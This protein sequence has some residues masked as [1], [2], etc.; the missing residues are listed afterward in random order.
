MDEIS[1][2][3][4][5]NLKGFINNKNLGS[6]DGNWME[7]IQLANIHSVTGILGY[8]VM[9]YPDESNAQVAPLMRKQCL[10]SIGIFSQ[11]AEKMKLLLQQMNEQG[12]DHLLF[13]GYVLKDY[14][15]VPELRSYGDIDF[16]IRLDDR[17]KS[18]ALMMHNC[19]ERKTDW[20]PVFSYLKEL[21][22]YEI[23]TDVMEVDVSDKADY[24][25]YFSHTW[26]RAKWVEG[27][28]WMLSPEDHL[29]YLLTH[30]AKH[31][32][33]SGAGI[34]MYMDIAVFLQHFSNDLDWDYLQVELEKLCFIDFVNM[35]LSVVHEYFGI[36]SPIPLKQIDKQVLDDFMEFTMAGGTFGHVGRDSGLIYLKRQDRNNEN[37]SR[38]KTLINRAFPSAKSIESRYTYLQGKHWLLPVAWV[39]RLF[40]TKD[41]WVHHA[42]EA[43]SIMNTDTEEVLK[44]KRIYK[45]IGL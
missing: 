30:I 16:L 36:A 6:F 2:Y 5:K 27:H 28:T 15:P 31:I 18:D 20:E 40:R 34:R 25:E 37:V 17:Q 39:H 38:M 42:E 24:K 43:Q 21:E 7:L 41:T 44:L 9:S 35:V 19:F 10:Q 29:V 11:R 22:Y 23:H 32:S 4:L 45:E 12:I 26:E 8:M 14:Y 1:L 13:K 3:L 33:S